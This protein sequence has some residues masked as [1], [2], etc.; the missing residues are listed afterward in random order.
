[1]R[2][3]IQPLH[4]KQVVGEGVSAA[5]ICLL[6]CDTGNLYDGA[7]GELSAGGISPAC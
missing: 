2:E 4:Q 6:F 1:M 5:H 3:I 7:G